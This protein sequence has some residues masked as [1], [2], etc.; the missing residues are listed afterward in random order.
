MDTLLVVLLV[1][2]AV[3]FTTELLS[4]IFGL[5]PFLNQV[6]VAMLTLPVS[7]VYHSILG[8]TYPDIVIESTATAFLALVL[9][10]IVERVNTEPIEIR[11]GKRG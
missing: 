6:S 11:R 7:V 10:V 1:S 2:F 3:A 9:G 4:F 8:T 5:I